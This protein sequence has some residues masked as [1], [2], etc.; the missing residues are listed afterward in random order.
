MT[1]FFKMFKI[2]PSR[3][4][5]E[6][7]FLPRHSAPRGGRKV[8]EKQLCGRRGEAASYKDNFQDNNKLAI[9]LLAYKKYISLYG[10][11]N[12]PA[13]FILKTFIQLY[14]KADPN[15]LGFLSN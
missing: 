12:F 9:T 3:Q 13:I 8:K 14:K 1:I 10:N 4:V 2:R 11:L 7:I 5:R 6:D 15:R